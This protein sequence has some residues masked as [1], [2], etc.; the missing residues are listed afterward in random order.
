MANNGFPDFPS[1]RVEE[2]EL[3][4]TR[5][6]REW[7]ESEV[8][9][10]RLELKEDYEGLLLPAMKKLF[11]DIEM[12]KLIWPE[13]YGGAEH[14][15]K[16]VI[17][18]LLAA[19]EEIG[20][21]DTGIGWVTAS[22]FALC[23]SFA[24]ESTMNDKLCQEFGTLSCQAEEPVTGS[25]VLPLY[26]LQESDPAREYRG[27]YLQVV[28]KKEGKQ[29]ILTGERIR[30]L[31][32]SADAAY[33]GVFCYLEGEDEPGLILVPA[34][35]EGIERDKEIPKVT[36][37]AASRNPEIRFDRVAVPAD[38]LVFKGSSAYRKMLSWLHAGIG[39]VTLGSLFA[40][41]EIIREWGDT[42]VIKGT[43]NIFKNNPLTASLMA[44]ISHQILLSRFLIQRLGQLF[45]QARMEQEEDAER[46]FV[47]SLSIAA[48]VT[49][50]AEKAINN[51]MELMASAGYATE[52]NLERY[53]RDVKTMQV[54]LGNWELNKMELAE[55]FYD[56]KIL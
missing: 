44:E 3:S 49:A 33:F 21:A 23:T 7:A 51:I 8:I 43:G 45:A 1:G 15:S 16:D 42:R 17:F 26:G 54:H 19:L 31:N 55:Y 25:L 11:V 37:L 9:S 5:S 14:N 36:G 34:S 50:A 38:N 24:L 41:F 56:S 10:K 52:W 40:S 48:H 30:P 28:A 32:A 2:T 46:L 12:Q 29:W 39:A 4:L 35:S 22:T 13:K 20:R 53:W 47:G 6:L 27:R 18:T